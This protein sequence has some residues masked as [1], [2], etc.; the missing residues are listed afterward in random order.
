MIKLTKITTI[1]MSVAISNFV[2]SAEI[3]DEYAMKVANEA[4]SKLSLEEKIKF[5]HGSGTMTIGANPKI[6]L[7][8]EF[9]MSDSSHTVRHDMA[10]M[11]WDKVG[12]DNEATVMPA[13]QGLAQTWDVELA[14]KFGH[15]IGQ[16][17]RDRGKDMMLGPGVNIHRTPICG[18]N[19]EYMSEDPYLSSALT[20]PYI[21][22]LQANGVAATV[23]HF[24]V[25]NQELNRNRVDTIVDERTLREIYLPAF[26]AAVVDAGTLALM[27][28]YNRFRG[29]YCSHSDYLN[30]KV[31]KEEWGYKGLVVTDWGGLHNSKAGALGGT[32]VEMHNGKRIKYF[33]DKLLGLVKS[34]KVPEKVID[35]KVRRVLFVM[36][37][38][39]KIG[40]TEPRV[41]GARNTKEH[42]AIART[43]AEDA[44]VLLKNE[45]QVLPLNPSTLKN[46]LLIGNANETHCDGGCSAIGTPPYEITSLAGIKGFLGSAVNVENITFPSSGTEITQIPSNCIT[47][48]DPNNKESFAVTGWRMEYFNNEDLK[49]EATAGFAREIDFKNINGFEI[50]EGFNGKSFSVRLRAQVVP[51]TSGIYLLKTMSND[52]VRVRVDGKEVINDWSGH[53]PRLKDAPIQL[54]KGT[55]YEF[56]V[57]Y[58]QGGGGGS[59]KFGWDEPGSEEINILVEKAKAADAVLI[60]TGTTHGGRIE[61]REEEMFDRT[62]YELPANQMRTVNA[63][64]GQ[65]PK[66]IVV[67]HSGTAV[68]LGWAKEK[69]PAIIQE[70]Y[71][72]Q[73][74]GNAL[75][76]VLFGKV[77]PSGRLTYT[78]GNDLNDYGAHALDTYNAKYVVYK[79]GI[80][81]GYRWFDKKEI[82]PV[83]PFGA[84][85]SY[86]TFSYAKPTL[87]K[88]VITEGDVVTASITVTN[89]GKMAGSEVVQVYVSDLE[90]SLPR[91]ARELKGF[92][93]VKLEPGESKTVSI[94]LDHSALAFFNPKKKGWVV[95]PGAFDIHFA[96]DSRDIRCSSQLV[97]Q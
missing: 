44:L 38:I 73:E 17:A 32:D 5:T 27:S 64:L 49:G 7:D 53:Q 92:A 30:N 12:D 65:N 4:L 56:V 19:W 18:R 6:G 16:E 1:L 62:Q 51:K 8:D 70:P 15:L 66:T 85:I 71:N 68:N 42:Q 10:R 47:T 58:Y 87:S 23:K 3:T 81:V 69:A 79:E 26:K 76:N 28:G 55:S 33:K 37:K 36:A 9:H 46:V 72:G 57:E 60:F 83:Y 34:G 77:N 41:K 97:L 90:S 13:L 96:H 35:D 74:A 54:E 82:E 91:P 14:Q 86:T 67:N 40:S 93:K 84:G 2:C 59:L 45:N 11:A 63:V 21:K 25:N 31:L 24:A 94:T 80:F 39:G 61:A 43:V 89:T 52:G 20:V 22:S 50:P 48:E 95:E 75:A 78:I 88:K 29:E